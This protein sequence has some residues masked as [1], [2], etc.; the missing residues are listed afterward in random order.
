MKTRT[1]ARNSIWHY[2]TVY[3]RKDFRLNKLSDFAKLGLGIRWDDGFI[4]YLNGKEIIRQNVK[5]GSG[6]EAK[7]IRSGE[8]SDD[9]I[10]FKLEPFAST[11]REGRNVIAIEGH[12]SKLESSDF[13]LDPFLFSADWPGE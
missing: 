1:I 9:Y 12:N 8:A 2:T 4:A 3:L 11:L 7:D 5:K 13:T 10:A 6:K